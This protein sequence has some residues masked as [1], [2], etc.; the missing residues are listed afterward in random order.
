MLLLANVVDPNDVNAVS[1]FHSCQGH[2]YP[3]PT[4]PN[5]AKNYFYPTSQNFSSNTLIKL[6]A[7]C[8]GTAKQSPQDMSADQQIRGRT[9]HLYCDGSSTR[10]KY[11]HVNFDAQVLGRH[12]QAG[13]QLGTASL[14]AE[15]QAASTQWQYS[16]D[17][18]VAVSERDDDHTEDY[19]SK[20]S[21][22]A[23]AA[24]SARGVTAATATT[25]ADN[26]RCTSYNAV[27]GEPDV[28]LFSPAR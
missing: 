23:L 24:W 20:L 19:F 5:S 21:G 1:A 25:R 26:P 4:A 18:D 12:V 16:S 28:I 6:F 17:F 2:A 7:A 11:F 9:L 3:Q 27:F 15:G 13:D 14:L 22:A 10:V 8:I